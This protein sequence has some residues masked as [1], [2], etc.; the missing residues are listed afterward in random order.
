MHIPDGFLD[1]SIAAVFY[2][3]S[4]LGEW[5]ATREA[6]RQLNDK[7][8]PRVAL[9]TAA[10]FA[11]QMLN[12]PIVGGTSG[13]LIGGTLLAFFFGPW[14][15]VFSLTV[16]IVLQAFVF[17]D[18]GIIALGANIFN[19]AII[20]PLIGYYTWRTI[21]RVVSGSN[22][23]ILGLGLGAWLSVVIASLSCGLQ[24]GL[25]TI[26][27]F[28]VL[29][30]VPAMLFWHVIIGLG[31]AII[32]IT[33]VILIRRSRPDLALLGSPNTAVEGSI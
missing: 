19:M 21:R 13:H 18:G 32:T 24:I 14:I 6:A 30:T 25:S 1:L 22:G 33:T 17:G 5:H 2:L 8:L 7:L 28:T 15:A 26:F 3:V 20:T 9:V 10:V 27:P 12:F 16:I 29:E 11:A 4:A 23:D 31:E